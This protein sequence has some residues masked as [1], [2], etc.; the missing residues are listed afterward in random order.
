MDR[1][2]PL[3][4][5]Q[6]IE[7]VEHPG[8]P[9]LILAGA[10]SGKT[11]TLTGRVIH[12]IRQQGV[13][14]WR[15]LAVTFTNK[16]AKE[17]KERIERALPEGEMPWVATFHSTCVRILRRDISALGFDTSFTIYDDQDQDRL[18]KNI[19]KELGIDDKKLKPR[20]AAA[21]IDAAKNRGQ[22]P[23]EMPQNTPQ[24]QVIADVYRHYQQRL[25]QANALDFGDLLLMCVKLFD[26]HEEIRQRYAGRFL[27]LLVDEFQD[28]NM[29]QYRLVQQLAS[30]HGNL[31]V[32]G[33]D[34]QSIYRWRGAEVGNILGFERDYPGCTTIRLE[35]NYRST[36]T[37]LD[38]AGAVVANNVG[39][40]GKTLWTEN[41]DGEAITL[42]ALPDDLEEARYVVDQLKALQ[43]GG[44]HLR[45]I[46]MLYRTNAQS[47]VLEE[48]LVRERIPYVMFGGMRFFA[49]MEVKDVLAYL[50]VLTNPADTISCQRIINVPTRGIGATTVAKI[51][52]LEQQAQ[53][54]FPACRLAV[55]QGVLK[56]AAAK[57]VAAFVAMMEDFAS[58]LER[59]PYPQL[60]AELIEETGYAQ[61]LKSEN[62]QEARDRLDNIDQLL[63]GMEEHRDE[64][65]TLQDYLEQ[66]ALV[67][68]LDAYDSSLDRVTLM[69]LHA[70][71]GLEF[72][73]VFMTGMEDGIFP[74]ARSN[75]GGE[76]LEEERRL[77]YVGMTRAMEKLYLTH[78]RRRRVYGSYQFNPPSRFVGEIPE[79]LLADVAKKPL[80]ATSKHNL[81]S[82][83][84]QLP[85]QA[86]ESETSSA[87]ASTPAADSASVPDQPVIEVEPAAPVDDGTLR[88]GSRV[89]H[90]RFGVGTV[91]RL[92]GSG[93]K[94]KVIVYFNRFGP[95][96]L[97]LKFAGLEPA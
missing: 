50:R 17:M 95:K 69:T 70:A 68:D 85:M 45:D 38:A 67:T 13:P 89:R 20:A 4:N 96:R 46:A 58:R 84:D 65:T 92:E 16:A 33:D 7:A 5:P 81:A 48:A 35:Q 36:T 94:Q 21:A 40:K 90:A 62:T 18:L 14:P 3:L 59:L 53:G 51:A 41:P 22:F 86:P 42:E 54:F 23:A 55:E 26:E 82:L 11:S 93:D 34:D 25:Q 24:E 37:I 30:E 43:Q 61:M 83:F 29:V 60:A 64:D 52:T 71:K 39:R 6:Q 74:A 8:G 88:I 80:H 9:L 15:I 91:R 77:C 31:C 12:L 97:L 76:Q 49:R 79:G 32:V 47:R 44:R 1:P 28:T 57:K 75:D 72:P 27:H 2:T 10:G 87:P 73:V 66:V 78:A 19:L 56:G 63:A